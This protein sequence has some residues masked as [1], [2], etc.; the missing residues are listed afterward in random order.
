M[1]KNKFLMHMGTVLHFIAEGIHWIGGL[2]DDL[3]YRCYETVFNRD[4]EVARANWPKK[5]L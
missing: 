5:N 4:L 2:F 3:C 1:S